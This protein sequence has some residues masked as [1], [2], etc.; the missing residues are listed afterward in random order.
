MFGPILSPTELQRVSEHKYA[1]GCYTPLDYIFYKH[2][3]DPTLNLIPLWM[4]PNLITLLGTI[5]ISMSVLLVLLLSTASTPVP[6]WA[7][8]LLAASTF[9]YQTLDAVDGRQARR[10]GSSSPL[11]QL[12]DH[13]CD[14][15]VSSLLA[16]ALAVTLNLSATPLALTFLFAG[17]VPFFLGQWCEHHTNV[18]HTNLFGLF[19]TTEAQLAVIAVFLTTAYCGQSVW[20]VAVPG[21]FTKLTLRWV[22][23]LTVF[24]NS[25]VIAANFLYKTLK[26]SKLSLV[27]LVPMATLAW[28]AYELRFVPRIWALGIFGLA[29]VKCS[30]EIIVATVSGKQFPMFFASHG[31]LVCLALLDKFGMLSEGQVRVG[32]GYVGLTV[33]AGLFAYCV[34]VTNDISTHLGI[35]VFKIK[36]T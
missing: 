11:G 1:P 3:W 8:Y 24:A 34:Q 30:V 32:L 28:A 9:I 4:A 5:V 18:L 12:F 36:Y 16:T 2:I 6:A 29:C 7:F 17:Q 33:A 15:L 10:T 13:G 19:G 23:V 31:P 14:C 25:T 27:Q 26:A 21:G 20:D 35:R 22:F